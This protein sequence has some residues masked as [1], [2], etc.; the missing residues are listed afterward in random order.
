MRIWCR[1]IHQRWQGFID[2]VE[3]AFGLL[4][5][6]FLISYSIANVVSAD[7]W[8]SGV[9]QK[10]FR[11][12]DSFIS[13]SRITVRPKYHALLLYAIKRKSYKQNLQGGQWKLCTPILQ[14]VKS[15]FG[16]TLS[17]PQ[18]KSC[19]WGV[20]SPQNLHLEKGW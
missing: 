1:P 14:D 11:C 19:S 18:L 10:G 5:F 4:P 16:K 7:R 20:N 13:A 6:R 3:A 12:N 2:G 15:K 8:D 17:T 9:K